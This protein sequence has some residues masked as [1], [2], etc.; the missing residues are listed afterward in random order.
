LDTVN[1]PTTLLTTESQAMTSHDYA[2]STA[3]TK[4]WRVRTSNGSNT[5]NSPVWSFTT[6]LGGP[7]PPPAGSG[8]YFDL[9]GDGGYPGI[10]AYKDTTN[11]T[12]AN[13][14][15][16]GW[17]AH[18]G[19]NPTKIYNSAYF[20]NAI[21]ADL[22]PTLITDNPLP[23][24]YFASHT[25]TTDS[26]GNEWFEFDPSIGSPNYTIQSEGLGSKKVILFARNGDVNLTGPITLTKGQGSFLLI[27]TGNIIVDPTVGSDPA[28]V[29]EASPANLEGIF[30]SDGQ[31][32]TGTTG[33]SSDLQL[34][35]RGSI[36]AYGGASLQR[37][38]GTYNPDAP[39]E[40]FEFAPDL[41]LQF[42]S[43][44]GVRNMNW[45]EVAP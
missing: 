43:I 15:E 37:N 23:D 18:S 8:Y 6:S 24:N 44:L 32:R 42:P 11:L 14:S 7:T 36:A 33:T 2:W 41:A 16:E 10:P 1:P 4:Y 13:V 30:V 34:R 9:K 27:T 40:F 25:G 3:G 20:I 19:Y 17:L 26:G 28:S 22:V 45:Q 5:A 29:T 31:F 35:V 39:A 38:L 12:S 21:P